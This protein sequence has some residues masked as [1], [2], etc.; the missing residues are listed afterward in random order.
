M[1][2][3]FIRIISLWYVMMWTPFAD[4]EQKKNINKKIKLMKHIFCSCR[5]LL[6]VIQIIFH[7]L[8]SKNERFYHWCWCVDLFFF[9]DAH[10]FFNCLAFAVI[11]NENSGTING[12]TANVIIKQKL[13]DIR[14][15]AINFVMNKIGDDVPNTNVL[16]AMLVSDHNWK[17]GSK[18]LCDRWNEHIILFIQFVVRIGKW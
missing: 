14:K 18:W 3:P 6:I 8:L 10:R 17:I 16:F 5:S 15:Y 4:A 1:Q 2:K 12:D 11:A 7:I 13:F 9:G